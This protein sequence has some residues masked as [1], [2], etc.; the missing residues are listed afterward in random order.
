MRELLVQDYSLNEERPDGA[1][2][3]PLWVRNRRFSTTWI[4]IQ[5]DPGEVGIEQ[6]EARMPSCPQCLLT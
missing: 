4:Y 3:E 2:R 1:N 5:Q 6:R